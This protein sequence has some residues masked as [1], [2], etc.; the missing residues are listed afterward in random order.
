M[1]H[2]ISP[3]CS[4]KVTP[5]KQKT[6]FMDSVIH[7]KLFQPFSFFLSF[8]LK[9]FL[10]VL[11]EAQGLMFRALYSNLDSNYLYKCRTIVYV[12]SQD[13]LGNFEYHL[14]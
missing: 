8:D 13:R 2:D 4:S 6:V 1:A 10:K 12:I 5:E 3:L 14:E 11:L 9:S 7:S